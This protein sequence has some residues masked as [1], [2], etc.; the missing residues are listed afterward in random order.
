MCFM[1]VVTAIGLIRGEGPELALGLAVFPAIVVLGWKLSVG[2]W[3]QLTTTEIIVRNPF[4]V[5]RIPL[6]EVTEVSPRS[7]L[8]TKAL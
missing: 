5:V 2:S 7:A 4:E 1:T 8:A 6:R 3:R